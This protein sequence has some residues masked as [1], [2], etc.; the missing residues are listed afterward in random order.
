MFIYNVGKYM[1]Y[2]IK[3]IQQIS[4]QVAYN[5]LFLQKSFEGSY[6]LSLSK[7]NCT[8]LRIRKGKGC[9]QNPK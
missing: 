2:N 6:L 5:K 9:V 3:Y 4:L 1:Y 7:T 8:K